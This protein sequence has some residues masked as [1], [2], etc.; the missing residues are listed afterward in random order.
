MSVTDINDKQIGIILLIKFKIYYSDFM[1]LIIL[2]ILQFWVDCRGNSHWLLALSVTV[3]TT[4][5]AFYSV[6]MKL[7]LGRSFIGEF[8]D[9]SAYYLILDIWSIYQNLLTYYFEVSTTAN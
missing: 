1:D 6:E 2:V 3:L 5:P 9:E 4:S 8:L 7:L